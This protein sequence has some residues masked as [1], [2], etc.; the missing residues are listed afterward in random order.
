MINFNIATYND[1]WLALDWEKFWNDTWKTFWFNIGSMFK[2][3]GS[4]YN[5]IFDFNHYTTWEK[6]V[7]DEKWVRM[8]RK[9][10]FEDSSRIDQ[11]EAWITTSIYNNIDSKW[12][13]LVL[14]AWWWI[15]LLWNF[16]W[17]AIQ[18]KWHKMT[19][20]YKH[21]AKYE[22]IKWLAVDLRWDWELT[23]YLLW[24]K[25]KGLYLQWN[26][27][28]K[29]ASDTKHWESNIKGIVSAGVD[30][31]WFVVKVWATENYNVW[32]TVSKTI[33]W[34]LLDNRYQKSTFVEVGI[35]IPGTDDTSI[36]YNIENHENWDNYMKIKLNVNF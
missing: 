4:T 33:E 19:N 15:Q 34:A 36:S 27:A 32:P 22:K 35:H 1:N 16:W 9:T 20:F 30:S 11:L 28:F 23:R 7:Y 31:K 29:L 21:K 10:K 26:I 2:F 13:W 25:G 12:N 5:T 14:N 6:F 3:W 17:E 24:K 8:W 18:K